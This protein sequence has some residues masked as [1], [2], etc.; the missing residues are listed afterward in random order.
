MDKGQKFINEI[1]FCV[2]TSDI[3]KAKALVQYFCEINKKDQ[4]RVLYEIS[5]SPDEIALPVLDMLCRIKSQYLEVEQKIYG[6][7]LETLYDK[8]SWV[9]SAI[10]KNNSE[11]IKIYLRVA[12]DL[13]IGET[14]SA[15]LTILKSNPDL[16]VVEE[17]IRTLGSIG[18]PECVDALTAFLSSKDVVLKAFGIDA[19]SEIGTDRAVENLSNAIS[20]DIKTDQFIIT[21]LADVQSSLSFDKL[22]DLLASPYANIRNIAIDNLIRIGPKVVPTLIEK[23]ACDDADLLVHC[24]T[25]L[26]RVGDKSAVPAIQRLLY[27]SPKHSNVRYTAYE[28]LGALPS[29]QSSI[30]LAAGLEDPDDQ[31]RMVAA[32]AID[33][34]LSNILIAGLKN[35][36]KP[37]D[38][39]AANIVETFIESESDAVFDALID[40]KIFKDMAFDY[41]KN[42]ASPHIRE[43]YFVMLKGK[44]AH[45]IVNVLEEYVIQDRHMQG[46]SIFAIDDS[47]MM[48]KLYAKKL[49]E[50]G[51]I[52][53][54][55]QSPLKALDELQASK[56]DLVI[57]DL[58]MP[59]INGL[60]VTH[61]IRQKYSKKELPIIMITTQSDFV[62][63]S[64]QDKISAVDEESIMKS[65]VTAILHKPFNTTKLA[66]LIK[67]TLQKKARLNVDAV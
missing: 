17:C 56:P 64:S 45:D 18:T 38:S 31:V 65:G 35:M 25:I 29:P 1:I 8:A 37:Q 57:T 16:K 59:V 33:K 54:T 61:E 12:G 27:E 39:M 42:N 23:L 7:L 52:V 22:S 41:L 62:I 20:G 50:L 5:K 63:Q 24:L 60:Q 19:L 55:F 3:V 2:R 11:N 43:H 49:H 40:W 46:L 32:K 51:Y 26:G 4:M 28:A 15:V 44:G 30:R 36:I 67:M 34:N 21:G 10:L 53:K 6:L 48:L 13:K 9:N 47:I 14:V 58:N 66:D